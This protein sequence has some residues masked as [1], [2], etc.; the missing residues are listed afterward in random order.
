[1]PASAAG[2][3]FERI[4]RVNDAGVEFW[5]GRELARVLEYSEFRHFRPVIGKAREAGLNSVHR[6]EEQ[7]GQVLEMVSI[8]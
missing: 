8:G 5:S 6:V 4:K 2:N 1:M 7:F 3:T